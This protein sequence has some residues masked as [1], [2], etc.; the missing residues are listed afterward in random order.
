MLI[1]FSGLDG[2]GKSTL[3]DRLLPILEQTNKRVI[4][5]HMD[6]QFGTYAYLRA[7]RN[8]LLGKRASS[9]GTSKQDPSSSGF[10]KLAQ[11]G[12]LK[13]KVLS[14]RRMII[15]NKPL[16]RY[17][18]LLDLI[19]FSLY[20]LYIEK[21]KK[22]VLIM[23]RY[24]YDRLV[25]LGDD[26]KGSFNRLLARLTP[27]PSIPIYLDISP[28]E[29]LARKHEQPLEYLTRRWVGYHNIFPHLPN[30]IVLVGSNDL[31]AN[32]CVLEK[33]VHKRTNGG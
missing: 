17:I 1:T 19:T 18:Y 5:L 6:H 15:W 22:R 21:I 13:A 11:H 33:I 30:S 27:N 29:A 24:F 28:Q 10:Q 31:N 20:R 25:D 26:R 9:N 12:R 3:I 4:V 7:A 8:C 23:D 2:A 14:L 16:R 32:L